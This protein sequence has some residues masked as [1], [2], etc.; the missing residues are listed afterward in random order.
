MKNIIKKI[1][2]NRKLIKSLGYA[3]GMVGLVAGASAFAADTGGTTTATVSSIA[4]NVASS[5]GSTAIIL[6]DVALLGGVGFIMA[7]L[8]KFWQ[9][10]LNPT[11]I[12]ISQG[13]TLL[14]V[15]GGLMMFP[16]LLPVASNSL[17]G[18]TNK[19]AQFNGSQMGTLLGV[20]DDGK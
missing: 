10:K 18:T 13:V 14:L 12:P 20:K 1:F 2:K 8:F 3:L 17:F 16:V 19:I 6:K 5:A 9:H 7:A 15:G 4:T 11:Q